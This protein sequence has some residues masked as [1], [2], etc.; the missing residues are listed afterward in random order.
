MNQ[1]HPNLSASLNRIRFHL[2]WLPLVIATI[3][4]LAGLRVGGFVQIENQGQGDWLG[5]L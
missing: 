5:F 3:A 1:D 4:I 2:D